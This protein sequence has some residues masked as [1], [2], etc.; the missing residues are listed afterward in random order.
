M[1]LFVTFFL[2]LDFFGKKTTKKVVAKSIKISQFMMEIL[3]IILEN[4]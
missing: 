1:Y 4:F 3:I 2:I